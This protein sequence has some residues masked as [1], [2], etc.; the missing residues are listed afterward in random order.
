MK[1]ALLLLL[2]A[3]SSPV[4]PV[5]S[6]TPFDAGVN[7]AGPRDAGT[8]DSG[9]LDA[10]A[11]ADAGNPYR[12]WDGGTCATKTD[13]PCFSSDDCGPGFRCVSE[14]SSGSNVWCLPGARGTGAPG[15]PCAGEADC[16]SALCVEPANGAKL[17]SRL[18]DVPADC[19][20]S[21]PRCIYIGF[22]VDR[23]I[24]SPPP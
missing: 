24:C 2:A 18:C 21:L 1:R 19:P 22:G 12:F 15:A 8:A 6:G 10:G 23:S 13:C 17:C 4:T 14:D 16:A 5:D 7:D 3:C 20:A 9:T 11:P